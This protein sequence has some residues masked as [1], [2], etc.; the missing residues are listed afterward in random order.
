MDTFQILRYTSVYRNGTLADL[1]YGMITTP[2]LAQTFANDL[3][4]SYD[5]ARRDFGAAR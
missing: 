4:S 3:I 2:K 5:L 1:F